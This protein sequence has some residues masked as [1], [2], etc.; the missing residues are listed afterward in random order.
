[1]QQRIIEVPFLVVPANPGD[2]TME[3]PFK[4]RAISH[5]SCD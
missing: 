5:V 2:E 4:D 1:M 3:E